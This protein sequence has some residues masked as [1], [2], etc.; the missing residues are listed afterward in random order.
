MP[1]RTRSDI[2]VAAQEQH[3]LRLRVAAKL[4]LALGFLAVMYV[5]LSMVFSSDES[6][7]VV[8]TQRVD[9]SRLTPGQTHIVLWEG[10]PVIVYRRTAA[11][12]EALQN[13]TA[14]LDDPQSKRSRQPDWAKNSLRSREAEWF[15]G[16]GVGTDFSCPVELLPV[17]GEQFKDKPWLGGFVD[18]CRG[19]RYDL[20]GRVF[21]SQFADRNLIVPQ[22]RI[23]NGILL[24]G[25]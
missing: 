3:R 11:D 19:S 12:I 10:R 5:V 8:P 9:I 14:A 21:E 15:V 23:N 13:S 17:G 25:G 18:S 16:I 7:R 24:L 2:N 6:T 20:A 22:Y 1:I 4:M